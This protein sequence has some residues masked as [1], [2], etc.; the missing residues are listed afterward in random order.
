MAACA[1]GFDDEVA[2]E[3]GKANFAANEDGKDEDADKDGEDD[4]AD[5][6]GD[7][8]GAE[9]A[10]HIAAHHAQQSIVEVLLQARAAINAQQNDGCA[11]A[12]RNLELVDTLMNAGTAGKVTDTM[13]RLPSQFAQDSG[14][15]DVEKRRAF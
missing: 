11:P 15:E 6:D 13:D 3:N 5:E 12:F 8:D 14:Y 7:T 9:V 1:T 4:E 2:G 10:L